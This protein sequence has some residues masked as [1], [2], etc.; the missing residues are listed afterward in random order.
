MGQ[1]KLDIKSK[2]EEIQLLQKQIT[3]KEANSKKVQESLSNMAKENQQLS[4]RYSLGC[5]NLNYYFYPHCY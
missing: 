4:E 1:L 5:F 3:E 2:G